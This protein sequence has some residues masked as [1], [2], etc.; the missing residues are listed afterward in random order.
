MSYLFNTFEIISLLGSELT[1]SGLK[2][3]DLRGAHCAVNELE[4][5]TKPESAGT[6][7]EY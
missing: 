6:T 4:K 2:I 5:L 3:T 1:M 7:T